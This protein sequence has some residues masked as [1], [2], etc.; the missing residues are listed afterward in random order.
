MSA[1]ETDAGLAEVGGR[2][3]SES[4]PRGEFWPCP[5]CHSLTPTSRATCYRC[6]LPRGSETAAP[7][8]AHSEPLSPVDGPPA[9]AASSLEPLH[10]PHGLA[11]VPGQSALLVLEKTLARGPGRYAPGQLLTAVLSAAIALV[12]SAVVIVVA[13]VLPYAALLPSDPDWGAAVQAAAQF[14][15]VGLLGILAVGG[16]CGLLGGLFAT[17]TGAYVGG[18]LALAVMMLVT[19]TGGLTCIPLAAFSLGWAIGSVIGTLIGTALG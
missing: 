15:V 13:V 3:G 1:D 7:D 19:G 18:L 9:E 5:R 14:V 11:A 17:R 6:R 4:L 2:S 8:A 16:V 10:V 12:G